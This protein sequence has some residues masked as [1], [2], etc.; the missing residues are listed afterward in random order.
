[1]DLQQ[2][3]PDAREAKQADQSMPHHNEYGTRI[4]ARMEQREAGCERLKNEKQRQ[5]RHFERAVMRSVS[6]DPELSRVEEEHKRKLVEIENDDGPREREAERQAKKGNQDDHPDTGMAW[7]TRVMTRVA[8]K[9]K[10][11]D[12]GECENAKGQ[13]S[14]IVR[15]LREEKLTKGD[16]QETSRTSEALR[17]VVT[18][19]RTWRWMFQ[20]RRT[21]RK[22]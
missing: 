19:T 2:D 3:V 14:M 7:T 4:R 21:V 12:E 20:L 13:D 17:R 10:P 18:R 16:I 11:E 8:R 22:S 1:M 5:D 6:D 9:R 15:C